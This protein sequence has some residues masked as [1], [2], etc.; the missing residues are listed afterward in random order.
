MAKKRRGRKG[1]DQGIYPRPGGW[2]QGGP[3]SPSAMI[4]RP[5]SRSF[6]TPDGATREEVAEKMNEA[7]HQLHIGTRLDQ[8]T[9]TLSEWLDRWLTNYMQK[10]M[11]ATTFASYKK[12]MRLHVRP[13]HRQHNLEIAPAGRFTNT[14]QQPDRQWPDQESEHH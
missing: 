3:G 4:R 8:N 7:L 14:I 9:V 5:A 12:E 10:K 1:R 11:R 6:N 2:P 13:S